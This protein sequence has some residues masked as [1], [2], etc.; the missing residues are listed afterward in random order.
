MLSEINNKHLLLDE[1]TDYEGSKSKNTFNPF[2]RSAGKL[3]KNPNIF[4]SAV[5]ER[6]LQEISRR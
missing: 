5:N 3:L 1:D 2:K 4:F 6:E